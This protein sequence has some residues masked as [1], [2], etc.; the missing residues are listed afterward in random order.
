[1][2]W[3]E[4]TEYVSDDAEECAKE[5][6]PVAHGEKAA[7]DGGAEHGEADGGGEIVDGAGDHE[8]CDK[9]GAATEDEAAAESEAFLKGIDWWVFAYASLLGESFFTPYSCGVFSARL[10]RRGRGQRGCF[11]ESGSGCRLAR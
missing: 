2:R 3:L 11:L 7:K 6:I 9:T 10:A 4:S 8:K 5:S 1:M